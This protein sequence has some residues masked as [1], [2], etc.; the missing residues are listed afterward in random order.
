[1]SYE[2]GFVLPEGGG[3]CGPP[4]KSSKRVGVCLTGP[5]FL[6]VDCSERGG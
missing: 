2:L 1:M 4:T 3:E 5:Q 6:E